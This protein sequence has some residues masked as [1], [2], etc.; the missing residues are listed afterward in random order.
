MSKL[1]NLKKEKI[2]CTHDEIIIQSGGTV[3]V[4]FESNLEYIVLKCNNEMNVF[5]RAAIALHGVITT[6]PFIDGNKRTGIALAYIIL[7]SKGYKLA[8]EE[9]TIIEFLLNIAQYKI[10]VQETV[11]WLM[12]NSHFR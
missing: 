6:H 11:L 1:Y 2:I 10:T 12:K 9:D 3:G 7:E 4:L 8:S 5:K